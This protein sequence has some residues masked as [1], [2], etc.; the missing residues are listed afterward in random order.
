MANPQKEHGYTAI[1]NELMEALAR[2]S[3]N[4][5]ARRVLDVIFRKTYGFSKK[6]DV[7][8]VSQI[9]E[10]TGITK[11]NVFRGLKFLKEKNIIHSVKNDTSN[12]ATYSINKDYEKWGGMSV[13]T[14]VS[15]M[16][17][18]SVNALC[19]HSVRIDTHKNNKQFN[20]SA[21]ACASNINNIETIS[22]PIDKSYLSDS[23]IKNLKALFKDQALKDH[24]L[25]LGFSE[26]EVDEAI[27]KK[28]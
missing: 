5:E 3:I 8:S 14:L 15:K 24:L 11:R 25:N 12:I 21:R 16:V 10:M 13:S 23:N 20:K 2:T 19:E 27:G 18:G 6:S 28:Y 26:Y 7:I 4:G 22:K 9:S 1:S 17:K